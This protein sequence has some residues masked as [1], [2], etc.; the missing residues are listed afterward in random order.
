MLLFFWVDQESYA[1]FQEFFYPLIKNIHFGYSLEYNHETN[2]D[3]NQLKDIEFESKYVPNYS[4]F[5]I[6]FCSIKTC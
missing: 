1:V 6:F 4:L 5:I 2:L 3:V